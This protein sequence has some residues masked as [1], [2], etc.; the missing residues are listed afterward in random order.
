MSREVLRG[1]QKLE[2]V[3][4]VHPE[5]PPARLNALGHNW[6]PIVTFPRLPCG[7]L[8]TVIVYELIPARLVPSIINSS[9]PRPWFCMAEKALSGCAFSTKKQAI[10]SVLSAGFQPARTNASDGPSGELTLTRLNVLGQ[11]P[12]VGPIRRR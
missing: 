7:E 12:S 4:N 3:V 8:A 1:A 2:T 10:R 9:R 6:V 11:D 5:I